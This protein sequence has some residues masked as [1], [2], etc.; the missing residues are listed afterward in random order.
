MAPPAK[1]AGPARATGLHARAA[2]CRRHPLQPF[3]ALMKRA[4]PSRR[5]DPARRRD[6]CAA[7]APA[8]RMTLTFERMGK[9]E[10]DLAM[11]KPRSPAR[12]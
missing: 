3:V 12:R 2:R 10:N 4:L 5:R 6:L 8:D 7:A 1:Q 9:I 11:I